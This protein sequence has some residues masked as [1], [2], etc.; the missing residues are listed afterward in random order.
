MRWGA[1]TLFRKSDTF[2]L[3]NDKERE[4]VRH[5]LIQMLKLMLTSEPRD[6]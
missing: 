4:R 3:W 6:F 1:A 5:Y 2:L